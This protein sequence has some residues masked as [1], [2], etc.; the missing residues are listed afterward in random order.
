[1][2]GF[3]NHLLP[4]LYWFQNCCMRRFVYL[5][6]VLEYLSFVRALISSSALVPCHPYLRATFQCS[7]MPSSVVSPSGLF[8]LNPNQTKL[9]MLFSHKLTHTTIV[10]RS[11]PTHTQRAPRACLKVTLGLF[12][13]FSHSSLLGF[14]SKSFAQSDS[15]PFVLKVLHK[16]KPLLPKV[17]SQFLDLHIRIHTVGHDIKEGVGVG[18]VVVP[19]GV[20]SPARVVQRRA[21]L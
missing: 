12:T 2:H 14:S 6:H 8:L 9:S 4:F 10:Q 11:E 13:L 5:P 17:L 15:H 21:T 19:G 16:T 1:M 18:L 3:R 7:V 20:L